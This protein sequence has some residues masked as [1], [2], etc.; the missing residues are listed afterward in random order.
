MPLN[1]FQLFSVIGAEEFVPAECPATEGTLFQ[2][3]F[4][5]KKRNQR[6][7]EEHEEERQSCQK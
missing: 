5:S 2:L 6:D 3:L 1:I 4:G 7:E